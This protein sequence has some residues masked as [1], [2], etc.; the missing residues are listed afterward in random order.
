MALPIET[1]RRAALRKLAAARFGPIAAG[2]ARVLDLSAS[3][4]EQP[5]DGGTGG[6]V[7]RAAFLRW[8]AVDKD[9]A[10]HI[11]P[12]G[13]R[14]N[15]AVIAD[16]LDLDSCRVPF[17][18]RLTDCELQGKLSLRWSTLQ[19]L[20][21]ARCRAEKEIF[22]S[23]IDT[24]GDIDLRGLRTCAA[25]SLSGAQIGGN[26]LCGGSVLGWGGVALDAQGS[27]IRGSLSLEDGFSS[28]GSILIA[29]AQIGSNLNCPGAR[30]AAGDVALDAYGA[31]V[32][33]SV[34]LRDGFSACG[35]VH[36][37]LLRAGLDFDCSA[38]ERLGLL[39]CENM[40]VEG[41]MILTSLSHPEHFELRLNGARVG[42]F[43]DDRGS[44][45]VPG[46]LQIDGF[47]YENL[48]LH[49]MASP[50]RIRGHELGDWQILDPET[51]IEWIGLQPRSERG[52]AQPWMQL[53]QLLE[54]DGDPGGAKRVIYA[55]HRQ[56]AKEQRW[57][58]R[59]V[60]WGYNR[61]EENPLGISV[62]IVGFWAL[63]SLLFWRAARMGAMM[64][65]RGGAG[66][67]SAG[68]GA[69]QPVQAPFNPVVYALENVLPVVKLGQDAAWAPDP[70]AS[71]GTWLPESG[72]LRAWFDERPWT[73]WLA[74]LDYH[75]LVVARWALILLGWA[76]ALILAAAIAGA[77]RT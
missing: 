72:R 5:P 58:V 46:G 15:R 75:R 34:F 20:S 39:A 25:V 64:P 51:R 19:S 55:Y 53:A 22:A 18:L 21:L 30:I 37:T 40:R 76:M 38:A 49:A 28:A 16:D 35:A 4:E 10:L 2:E 61:I 1:A 36:F 70:Q 29:L 60:T 48:V 13:L 24:P 32:T 50:D 69:P 44:W 63:G 8:L 57:M 73:R 62:P 66:G 74:R 41:R 6:N 7:V 9:A 23:D 43:H 45:P 42:E 65:L 12:L 27:R 67:A 31:T 3:T 54:A 68:T 56:Q 59:P 47:V 52:G 11:D 14:V 77:F 71:A 17:P 26:L 33:G